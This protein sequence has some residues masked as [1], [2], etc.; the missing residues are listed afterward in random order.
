MGI[1]TVTKRHR[2]DLSDLGYLD[3]SRIPELD[4]LCRQLGLSTGASIAVLAI[5]DPETTALLF[6]GAYGIS[7][8]SLKAAN[9]KTTRSLLGQ[10]SK[11]AQ[12]IEADSQNETEA[13]D[14]RA[15]RAKTFLG[16]PVHGPA[17]KPIGALAVLDHLPRK[18]SEGD[19]R[20]VREVAALASGQVMMRAAL[21]TL[22]L[23][24]RL[25]EASLNVKN[26]H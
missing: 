23:M 21:E 9:V 13:D 17:G 14:M 4:M 26:F 6:K 25:S 2:F 24:S 15:F 8:V 19:H 10:V 12:L 3:E 5:A 22:K 11:T 7:H 18:W 1:D 20:S 16:A